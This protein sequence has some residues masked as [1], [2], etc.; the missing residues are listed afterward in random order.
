MSRIYVNTNV[1]SLTSFLLIALFSMFLSACGSSGGT[2]EDVAAEENTADAEDTGISVVAA[3]NQD[4]SK[5][6]AAS[7]EVESFMLR[8]WANVVDEN[9]CGTCHGDN[10]S[11]GAPPFA[12]T[13]NINLAY[14]SALGVVSLETPSSSKLVTELAGGHQCWAGATT[15]ECASDMTLWITNWAS[16]TLGNVSAVVQ[17]VAPEVHEVDDTKVLPATV[18]GS[19]NELHTLLTTNCIDCHVES[20][21]SAQ[22]PFFASS[23][24]QDSYDA[25]RNKI[26]LAD[27]NRTLASAL[28]R[29]VVRLNSESH[30]CWT[31]NCSSDAQE[32]LDGVIAIS[33]S[34]EP[35][36]VD[37]QLEISKGLQLGI[38][39][40]PANT[41]GRHE[42]AVIA[43][44]EFKEGSGATS[45]DSSGIQPL[46][47]LQFDG[48][49]SWVGGWGINLN[50]GRALATSN[51]SVKL[52][53]RI[54]ESNEYSI[55]TW[56]APNNVTQE[57]P[58]R[59]INYSA[60]DDNRNFMLGQTLYNYDFL[61]RS[62]S[63]DDTGN[64]ALSTDDDAERLQASLQHV[65]VTYNA[66]EGRRIYVNGEFTG[67][68]DPA[69]SESIGDWI[70]TYQFMLGT[71]DTDFT[72]Q[73]VIRMVAIHN[74]ALTADQITKNFEVGVGQK[75]L[76]LF[77][78]SSLVEIDDCWDSFVVFEAAEYDSYSYLFN[79][80]YFARIYTKQ[81]VGDGVPAEC[82]T[83]EEPAQSTY[84]FSISDMRLGINGKIEPTG[85]GFQKLV[86]AEVTEDRQVLSTIGTIF[87][88]QNGVDSDQF[89]LAF[90]EIAGNTGVYTD[91]TSIT[92]SAPDPGEMP[93]QI[94]LRTFEEIN[95]SLETM[96]TVASTTS[97]VAALYT[98]IQQQLP[99]TET[100][101]DFVPAHQMAIAQLAMVYCSALV[102]DTT[103]RDAYFAGFDFTALPN[104]A[105]DSEAKRNL[106]FN[107]L[108]SNMSDASVETNVNL[109]ELSAPLDQ[110]LDGVP[111]R[112]PLTN[113][114]G[115]CNAERT[116]TI[117]K[118]LCASTAGS[119]VM[120][121]Q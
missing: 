112:N 101:R 3:Y 113:C 21:Q 53:N 102:D 51:A 38:D 6:K 82:T 4:D 106:I 92:P 36:V 39:G 29:I 81:E 87:N 47:D 25:V 117:V 89:F 100:I 86:V 99:V 8:V 5:E 35:Q 98:E 76:L 31:V 108:L 95:A 45:R 70:N 49:V 103:K 23:N 105:F 17:L 61:H 11:T 22:S 88:Q 91:P 83:D 90:G 55:E 65:V 12:R 74:R 37:D 27:E 50:G 96:T 41:G 64:P 59:I 9:R 14:N 85:Q 1:R 66:Q 28:S 33:T 56:V 19:Y 57:G 94:G 73:G 32:L 63:S 15:Q 58:A 13:D 118:A 79:Q 107:P 2:G 104:T 110:L 71:Q 52:Y 7:V 40:L 75:F 84:N 20:A 120:L 44:W 67:D 68:E 78:V 48:D 97:T 30:N 46:M 93:D 72:W 16:D 18:P 111:G 115:N 116:Q 109:T 62:E 34:I 54:Q 10:P 24:Q 80:P 77:N 114:S 69:V 26:D 119:A 121:I 42:S 60:G 43:R